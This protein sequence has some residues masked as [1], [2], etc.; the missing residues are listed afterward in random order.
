MLRTHF[1]TFSAAGFL[2]TPVD[3]A[4]S[5][6]TCIVS[7]PDS[8]QIVAET[9]GS[10][11]AGSISWI[12]DD[13]PTDNVGAKAIFRI[14]PWDSTPHTL[15]ALDNTGAK[16]CES[17]V[18]A[19]ALPADVPYVDPLPMNA[20]GASHANVSNT[21]LDSAVDGWLA[22]QQR[23]AE[24]AKG[25][26][27]LTRISKVEPAMGMKGGSIAGEVSW[28]KQPVEGADV[29]I[30][31]LET[32]VTRQTKTSSAGSYEVQ[33]LDAGKYNVTVTQPGFSV[34]KQADVVVGGTPS[35]A[36]LTTPVKVYYATEREPVTPQPA[37]DYGQKRSADDSLR[38]GAA[39]VAVPKTH[40]HSN[41]SDPEYWSYNPKEYAASFSPLMQ[42]SEFFRNI[43]LQAAA[44]PN[45]KSLLVFVHG[46]N[47]SFREDIYK[48]AQLSYDTQFLG[49][50]VMFDWP[51]TTPRIDLIGGYITDLS[52]VAG[53][54]SHLEDFL[55][56]LAT[57]SG[58]ATINIVAH[59][60]GNFLLLETLDRMRA[61]HRLPQLGQIVLAAPDIDSG[62]FKAIVD[63]LLATHM[64]ARVTLYGSNKDLA[65]TLSKRAHRGTAAVG[66]MPPAPKVDG[67]DKIDVSNL[68]MNIIGHDYFITTRPVLNDIGALLSDGT[69]PPRVGF[70]A[71][72]G[73]VTYWKLTESTTH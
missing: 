25:A 30:I 35:Q 56:S 40:A 6:P 7:Q 22:G 27:A 12:V 28:A 61:E 43:A 10:A 18:S 44:Y 55:E 5:L 57:T 17:A 59:S 73:V 37:I 26:S 15:S 50:P 51:A 45:K 3:H 31:N 24:I 63:P 42:Q 23:P 58:G 32:G 46:F 68:P 67:I 39:V 70:A 72:P 38:Y 54:E 11:P 13:M 69:A 47:N 65:M 53:S 4:A 64:I 21:T 71:V 48:T 33:G 62:R 14:E 34:W 52:Q 1:L 9:P 29:Q 36:A 20:Q 49:V 41:L 66:S 8:Q 19:R 60:M 2:F 16:L